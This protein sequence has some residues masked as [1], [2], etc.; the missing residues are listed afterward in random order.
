MNPNKEGWHYL[1]VPKLAALF[2]RISLKH[3]GD[4]FC[5]NYFHSY[6]KKKQTWIHQKVWVIKDVC[7]VGI[8]INLVFNDFMMSINSNF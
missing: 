1:A 7:G 4:F 5:L 3:D 6:R 8:I 2:R